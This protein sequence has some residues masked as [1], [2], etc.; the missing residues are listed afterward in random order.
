MLLGTTMH[1]LNLS[2]E[3]GVYK[4]HISQMPHTSTLPLIPA[5]IPAHTFHVSKT[6]HKTFQTPRTSQAPPALAFAYPLERHSGQRTLQLLQSTMQPE[7]IPLGQPT[8][9]T[10]RTPRPSVMQMQAK[11]PS[12]EPPEPPLSIEKN[13]KFL[14]DLRETPTRERYE[15][16]DAMPAG[17]RRR[18]F[19]AGETSNELLGQLAAEYDWDNFSL[20]APGIAGLY[21]Y[22]LLSKLPYLCQLE[23]D[24]WESIAAAF[25]KIIAAGLVPHAM[26][27]EEMPDEDACNRLMLFQRGSDVVLS[28]RGTQGDRDWDINFNFLS[29]SDDSCDLKGSYHSGYLKTFNTL[30]ALVEPELKRMREE[31]GEPL[32]MGVVGHSMGGALGLMFAQWLEG[33]EGYNVKRVVTLGGVRGYGSDA[34]KEYSA[35]GLSEKTTRVINFV[36]VVP[37]AWPNLS[38][39][40]SDRLFLTI[41]G[42]YWLNPSSKSMLLNQWKRFSGAEYRGYDGDTRETSDHDVMNYIKILSAHALDDTM[43]FDETK[44]QEE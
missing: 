16:L 23:G 2:P 18:I 13:L 24:E 40:E 27:E 11:K 31:C 28:V 6:F 10:M 26:Y 30:L 32:S 4:A 35:L 33:A 38:H 19:E 22:A 20:D 39:P 36:D 37:L 8:H 7:G 25:D 12:P 9:N 43:V 17:M 34:V 44:E 1:A 21:P 41:N 14:G 5:S 15:K 3:Y 29:G 42:K